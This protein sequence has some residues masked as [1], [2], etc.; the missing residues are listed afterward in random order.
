ML[1][2][3]RF[4]GATAIVPDDIDA[5]GWLAAVGEDQSA[6]EQAL[7]S[8]LSEAA[9][10]AAA[11]RRFSHSRV[12]W[13]LSD[14]MSMMLRGS[15]DKEP[16]QPAFV[17]DGGRSAIPDDFSDDDLNFL[18]SIYTRIGDVRVRG[19]VADLVW[20]R[21]KG[22]GIGVGPALSAIE[23]YTSVRIDEASWAG[24]Q[25]SKWERAIVLC[26][27]LGRGEAARCAAIETAIVDAFNGSTHDQGFFPLQ[28]SQLLERRG[29]AKVAAKAIGEK[30]LSI[31]DLNRQVGNFH[32][33]DAYAT[34]AADWFSL[35]REPAERARALVLAAESL[36]AEVEARPQEGG[37]GLLGLDHFNKAI[38][39]YRSIPRTQ[40]LS[41]GVDQRIAALELRL[42]ESGLQALDEMTAFKM[43][44]N[45]VTDIVRR[46]R[47][48]VTGLPPVEALVAFTR[49]LHAGTS[50]TS[51]K[52]QVEESHRT[53]LFSGMFASMVIGSD[54]RV[55]ARQPGSLS[56]E[57]RPDGRSV[58]V[59]ADMVRSYTLNI[60][61]TTMVQI[62]PALE[63]LKAEHALTVQDFI[64]ICRR[65]SIVSNDHAVML[66]KAL[67]AGFDQDFGI[68][69][70]LLAPQVEHIV[71]T[72]LKRREVSTTHL[73]DGIMSEVGLSSLLEKPEATAILG[74]D[75]AF[76]LEALFCDPSGR[77]L[78]NQ[79]AHGLLTDRAAHDTTS[80]YAWWFVLRWVLLTGIGVGYG[81]VVKTTSR[82]RR[83][84]KLKRRS[85][86]RRRLR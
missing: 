8:R 26:L 37:R 50:F 23:A 32:H 83:K 5:C 65:S 38:E 35:A 24:R 18:F 25:A 19:R 9:R 86:L 56:N 61:M 75:M 49:D 67:F 52:S 40:R 55:V 46:V 64:V 58:A 59:S 51:L 78:R 7:S 4:P 48:A 14:A 81:A 17:M 47:R 29:L 84:S 13:M 2:E 36:V 16:F 28:L 3:E 31:A 71:R 15:D 45:D 57:V 34:S 11:E 20:L 54:G 43:P 53:N 79:V 62:A 12:L 66:G 69:V 70:Y 30:L 76:E 82:L 39:T 73:K 1:V 60:G 85:S 33:A 27:G 42:S 63:V 80:I 10:R 21:K 74:Q 72:A 44:A 68:A 6:G 41:L 22:S 77:N